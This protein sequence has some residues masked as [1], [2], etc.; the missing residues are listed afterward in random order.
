MGTRPRGTHCP[1]G[2]S[3]F[4]T[5]FQAAPADPIVPRTVGT[6]RRSYASSHPVRAISM[7]PSRSHSGSSHVSI[8][9]SPR[10]TGWRWWMS[11]IC[12]AAVVGRV[13][14][15]AITRLPEH[16]Q[17]LPDGGDS[18]DRATS[19]FFPPLET[20]GE[21]RRLPDG[22]VRLSRV[23]LQ[24]ADATDAA[25]AAVE[26]RARPLLARRRICVPA[27]NLAHARFA[28]APAPRGVMGRPFS[29]PDFAGLSLTEESL[30]QILKALDP[31]LSTD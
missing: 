29:G 25:T 21:D 3:H 23:L 4:W 26:R 12:G 1:R 11:A 5:W 31:L 22:R 14:N 8:A 18:R 28:S 27:T 19:P 6:R 30:Q 15:R 17:S 16:S 24:G 2:R 9:P 20:L 10:M 13:A 7:D